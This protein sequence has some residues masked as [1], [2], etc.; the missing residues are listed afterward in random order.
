MA[1]WRVA[2]MAIVA[3]G[4]GAAQQ[5]RDMSGTWQLNVARSS[6]GKHAKPTSGTVVIEHHEPAFKYSGDVQMQMG[7]ETADRRTFA[8][9]G[10]IDGQAHPV[11]GSAGAGMLTLKRE[12]AST[13]VSEFRTKDGTLLETAKT[14]ISA[15]GKTMTRELKGK[16]ANGD[17]SWVEIYE[18]Q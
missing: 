11:T 4:M 16:G 3:M 5:V 6:W 14:T 13:V 1:F 10:S 9:D 7:S 18:R 8:F 15:D 17:V 12:N 2:L